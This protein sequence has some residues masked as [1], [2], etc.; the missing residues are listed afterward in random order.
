MPPPDSVA[1]PNI[2]VIEHDADM[3]SLLNLM[4]R[5]RGFDV[6][7][8]SAGQE[9]LRL[10]DNHHFDVVLSEMDLPDVTSLEICKQLRTDPKCQHTPFIMMS[11][12]HG[13]AL[14]RRV[15]TSRAT[16]FISKPFSADALVAKLFAHLN[17]P[18]S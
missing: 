11:G 14:E 9:A 6:T 10:L 5:G 16:D 15:L 13:D 1:K 7:A 2:L 17:K 18:S 3:L 4:L 12:D 8:A